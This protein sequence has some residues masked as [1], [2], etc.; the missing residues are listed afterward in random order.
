MESSSPSALRRELNDSCVCQFPG[1]K[2][3]RYEEAYAGEA[4]FVSKTMESP[5]AHLRVADVVE[6]GKAE[7][8]YG[9]P[10]R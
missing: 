1:E 2:T 3:R 9:Q 7:A 10:E 8:G 6:L 4:D 5:D